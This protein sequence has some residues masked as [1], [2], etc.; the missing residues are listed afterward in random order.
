MLSSKKREREAREGKERREM[1][2]NLLQWFRGRYSTTKLP[3]REH[4]FWSFSRKTLAFK[5]KSRKFD[6]LQHIESAP[7]AN[8]QNPS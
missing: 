6:S 5:S 8:T 1:E 7:N 2:A 3:S 4:H